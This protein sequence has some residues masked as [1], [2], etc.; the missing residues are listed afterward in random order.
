MRFTMIFITLLLAPMLSFADCNMTGSCPGSPNP[1]YNAD[2]HGSTLDASNM[3]SQ[4]AEA[5]AKGAGMDGK[6]QSEAG[7]VPNKQASES[8]TRKDLRRKVKVTTGENDPDSD[9]I[10]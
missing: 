8:L 5:I 1:Q 6:S 9:I 3:F 4:L 7:V 2:A 10:Q